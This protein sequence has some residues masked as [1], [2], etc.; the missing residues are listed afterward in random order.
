[1]NVLVNNAASLRLYDLTNPDELDVDSIRRDLLINVM[2]PIELINLFLSEL[3]EQPNATII[4]VSSPGGVVPISIVPI[5][6]ASKAALDSY[7]K[8]LREQLGESVKVMEVYPPSVDTEMN[9]YNRTR[10]VSVEEY[11]EQLMAS[12]AKGGDE[13][14]I[15]EAKYVPLMNRIAPKKTFRFINDAVQLV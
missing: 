8:S 5:Y 4:N 1:L 10:K 9:A 7:T 14:W 6:C 11:N 2:A 13:H 15:G 3:R 12:L